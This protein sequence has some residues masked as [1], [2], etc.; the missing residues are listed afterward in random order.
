M[1]EMTDKRSELLTKE[2]ERFS[3]TA[4]FSPTSTNIT[5]EGRGGGCGQQHAK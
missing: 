5:N 1:T 2:R 4:L 3:S